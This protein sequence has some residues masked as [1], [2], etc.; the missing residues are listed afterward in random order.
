MFCLVGERILLLLEWEG[1]AGTDCSPVSL[2]F[3]L[4]GLQGR[5]CCGIG[6]ECP[7]PPRQDKPPVRQG[8]AG[9]FAKQGA[10]GCGTSPWIIEA[11]IIEDGW[12]AVALSEGSKL[13]V[14]AGFFGG[15]ATDDS[16]DREQ[17]RTEGRQGTGE[18]SEREASTVRI[19]LD[20]ESEQEEQ[21]DRA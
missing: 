12:I 21:H 15:H 6:D 1:G 18:D 7:S 17:H 13:G 19:S 8:D 4:P 10:A 20:R 16:G 9:P 2:V 5:I 11:W 14:S 3:H